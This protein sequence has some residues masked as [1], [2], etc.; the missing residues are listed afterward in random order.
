MIS[1]YDPQTQFFN[2]TVSQKSVLNVGFKLY[3]YFPLKIKKLDDFHGF[4]REVKSASLN[5]SFYMIEEFFTVQVSV[6]IY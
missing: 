1:K 5:N 6:V 3:K 4:R 2:T